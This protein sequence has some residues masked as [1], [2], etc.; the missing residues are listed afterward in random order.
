MVEATSR[1]LLRGFGG[2]NAGLCCRGRGPWFVSP[3]V[4]VVLRKGRGRGRGRGSTYVVEFIDQ[5]APETLLELIKA[6]V[7]F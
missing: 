6:H 1:I 2:R 5:T 4:R 3:R 7:W